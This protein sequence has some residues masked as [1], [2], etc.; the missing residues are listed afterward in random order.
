MKRLARSL[1]LWPGLDQEIRDK[2]RNYQSCEKTR[3]VPAKALIHPWE[4]PSRPWAHV[5]IDHAGPVAGK[6]LLIIVD[7]HSKWIVAQVVP[8]TSASTTSAV[9]Q[10]VF[11]THGIPEQ[12]VF[13]NAMYWVCL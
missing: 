1:V 2:V 8:S 10:S 12:L 6:L 4:W 11:A 7:A 9:F 5:H 3:N 13:D